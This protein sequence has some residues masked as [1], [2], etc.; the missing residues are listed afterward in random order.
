MSECE[1][2]PLGLYA[3]GLFG[4]GVKI[5]GGMRAREDGGMARGEG[6]GGRVVSEREGR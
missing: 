4:E 2:V 6:G 5:G 3:F 1:R